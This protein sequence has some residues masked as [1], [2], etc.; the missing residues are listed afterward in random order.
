MATIITHPD[1]LSLS[2]NLKRFEIAASSEVRFILSQG[3]TVLIDE[4]YQPNPEGRIVIDVKEVINGKLTTQLPSGDIYRQT[5]IVK[6]FQSNINGQTV[7]FT[8][9]KAGV[10]NLT[11]TPGLFLTAN[12]LTWQPQVKKV[13]FNQ[14]EWLSYYSTIN[15]V[16]KV[17]F[18]LKD[19]TSV[20]H[21]L[22]NIASGNCYSYNMQ[23]SYIMGLIPGE[24]Y[25]YYDVFV[26]SLTGT[27]LTYIQR[28]IYRQEECN[29]EY[30][31]F[32][33]SIGGIDTAALT[34]ES[35]FVPEIEYLTGSY[36]DLSVQLPSKTIRKFEKN[37][38]WIP[39][40]ESQWLFDLLRSHSVFKLASGVLKKITISESSVE[41]TSQED[42]KSFTFTY[43][44]A[45]DTGLLNVFRSMDP[46]PE[47]L[48]ID[49]PTTG[50]FFLAP[51][52]VEFDSAE[53]DDNLL[54]PVQSPFQQVWKKF[55]WGAIWN[56]I[57][58]KILA[59]AIGTMAHAHDNFAV[60]SA[61]GTSS[62]KL[63]FNGAEIATGSGIGVKLGETAQTAYRG[64]RGKVGY[65]HSQNSSFHVTTSQKTVLTKLVNEYRVLASPLSVGMLITTLIPSTATADYINIELRGFGK[66]DAGPFTWVG[67]AFLTS[68]AFA[69]A[70]IKC[71]G[72]GEQLDVR[73]FVQDAVVKIWANGKNKSI[74]NFYNIKV[75]ISYGNDLANLIDE[76]SD[77]SYPT[78]G[79]MSAKR[80]S[81]FT[82]TFIYPLSTNDRTRLD[83]AIISTN[84]TQYKVWTGSNADYASISDKDPNTF[85]H[86]I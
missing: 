61:L 58:N 47:N 42:M 81:D 54:F 64:D 14:P 83:R 84:S 62:E 25:G 6:T 55:S 32:L 49:I 48:E 85:Y 37:S 67:Q 56:F 24:K 36:D 74:A 86:I 23:F 10:E 46:L 40:L 22:H 78:F 59:S 31:I 41:D 69:D 45:N 18:H 50:L 21:T 28:Y 43:R 80:F 7:E 16:V 68:G 9:I 11:E 29:D 19:G 5:K 77:S 60:L 12:W 73:I 27:R 51:R 8:A 3:E 2:S 72:S 39:K 4:T 15:S 26:E 75:N 79:V 66:V 33:N 53:P 76:I 30:Y 38:G 71:I 70:T 57:Y 35:S 13:A 82:E 52:L 34:G 65:D 44:M 63:T 1:T 20:I 17:R